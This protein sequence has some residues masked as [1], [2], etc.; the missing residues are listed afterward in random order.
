MTDR[1]GPEN[2]KIS[3]PDEPGMHAVATPDNTALTSLWAYR[4]N[5]QTGSGHTLFFDD[6]E[7]SAVV[8]NGACSMELDGIKEDLG[9]LDSFYMPSGISAKLVASEDSVIYIGCGKCEGTGKT[10]VRKYDPE[11][12]QGEIRQVHG[13]SPMK[14]EVFFTLNPEV[15]ATTLMTGLS[16]ADYG[17]WSSWPPHNHTKYFDEAYFYYGMDEEQFGVHVSYTEP[18]KPGVFHVVRSGDIVI[19]PKGYQTNVSPPGYR[20][21]YWFISASHT[22]GDRRFNQLAE[23]DPNFG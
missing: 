11:L 12:P 13:E 22:P 9:K 14:R 2:W 4:L 16:W 18:G 3:S 6:M 1:F 21:T 8:V 5:L 19:T 23:P 10:F 7:T 15:A 20:N 17:G